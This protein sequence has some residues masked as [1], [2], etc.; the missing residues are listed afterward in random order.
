MKKILIVNNNMAIGGVQKSLHNLLWAIHDRYD[1]TLCLFRAAGPYMENL[2]PDVKIVKCKGLFRYL[3]ISQ[4]QCR[5]IHKI[6]RG[7]LA[8]TARLFG[9]SAAVRLMLAGEKTLPGQFDCAVAFLHNGNVKNFYGGVQEFVLKKTRADKKVAF[10]HCDYSSCGSNHPANNRLI[11]QFDQIAACSEGCRRAF[12]SVLPELGKKCV[13]VRNF[14]RFDEISDLAAQ[15]PV[16]YQGPGAH[17]VMVSRLAHE[18]GIE[19]ALHAV[20][21]AR[22]KGLT[23]TLH[24]VGG[25]PMESMLRELTRSLQLTENVIFYGQQENPYRYMAGADLLLMTSFHEAAPMVIEE[26]VS[27]GIPVLTTRTTSSAEMVTQAQAGWVC[28]NDQTALTAAM[29]GILSSPKE[30]AETKRRLQSRIMDN[31]AAQS[32]FLRLIEEQHEKN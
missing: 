6:V 16:I 20:A 21:A 32:Q 1:V 17:V 31:T 25:G 27:L 12:Q 15:M 2:P 8:M 14:H 24:I 28:E 30:L 23:V 22:G 29:A 5:G 10:L 19:R 11:A 7:A 26:A 18:K 9:R 3:G 13:T 4:G